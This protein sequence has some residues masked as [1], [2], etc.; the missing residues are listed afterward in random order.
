MG[1]AG[2]SAYLR[3]FMK[4]VITQFNLELSTLPNSGKTLI[5]HLS[6]QDSF[7]Q[8]RSYTRPEISVAVVFV[9]KFDANMRFSLLSK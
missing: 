2:A 7:L 6:T 3:V 4:T 9:V 1:S 8:Y 5:S